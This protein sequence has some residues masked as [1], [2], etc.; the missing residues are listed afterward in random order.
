MGQG[1]HLSD[2]GME[3]ELRQVQGH[4]EA[5]HWHLDQP[6]PGGGHWPWRQDYQVTNE[7]VEYIDLNLEFN[8]S[9][10]WLAMWEAYKKHLIEKEKETENFLEQLS[11]I[12]NKNVNNNRKEWVNFM[13]FCCI[14]NPVLCQIIF[15]ILKSSV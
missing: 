1:P 10:E 15:Q 9:N 2:V 3:D 11:E 6:R 14:L 7:N 5:L 12:E 8:I 13:R 4:R